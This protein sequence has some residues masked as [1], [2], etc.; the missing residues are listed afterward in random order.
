MFSTTCDLTADFANQIG[1]Y[2]GLAVLQGILL[3]LF[4]MYTCLMA[5]RASKTLSNGAMWSILRAPMSFFD[6]TPLG[7]VL[8][9]FSKDIDVMENNLID[10]LRNYI[11]V[12]SMIVGTFVLVIAYFYYVS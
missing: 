12:L 5:T 1:I 6:T 8:H 3:F 7:G 4:F 10:A 9:R 2:A 11:V